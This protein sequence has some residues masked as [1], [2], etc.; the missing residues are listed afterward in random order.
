MTP[1]AQA[2]LSSARRPKSMQR[3]S[4]SR[5]RGVTH[6]VILVREGR[7]GRRPGRGVRGGA[8][9]LVE[10]GVVGLVHHFRA[11]HSHG[12]VLGTVRARRGAPG[13]Q[14]D[15]NA[16]LEAAGASCCTSCCTSG[17]TCGWARSLVAL[18]ASRASLALHP[19]R[20]PCRARLVAPRSPSYGRARTGRAHSGHHH[21]LHWRTA[22]SLHCTAL[23]LVSHALASRRVA[24]TRD[25]DHE[26]V[27]LG[28]EPVG[29]SL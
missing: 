5:R 1:T 12:R 15:V 11:A 26:Q 19:L 6:P 24:P 20:A 29:R 10:V 3:T 25:H 17:C 7:E 4:G 2:R 9:P 14:N 28:G 21:T 23:S 13:L 27:G 18:Q 8:G 16:V 22:P